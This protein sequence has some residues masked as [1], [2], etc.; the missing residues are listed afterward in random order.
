M[1]EH[2]YHVV[3]RFNRILK[4]ARNRL[5]SE[6]HASGYPVMSPAYDALIRLAGRAWDALPAWAQAVVVRPS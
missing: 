2:E 6:L 5:V 1:T 4:V 3:R